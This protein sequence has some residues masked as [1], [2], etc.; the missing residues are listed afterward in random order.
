MK[1]VEPSVLIETWPQRERAWARKLGRVRLGVEPVP[2]QLRKYRA[3]TWVITIVAGGMAVFIAALFTAFKS[4]GTGLIV[5][6]VLFG[7]V[8]LSAWLGYAKL[9]S[10]ALAYL[11]EKAEVDRVTAESTPLG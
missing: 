6:G 7:P 10:R 9:E 3:V 1:P 8:I 4:P 5:A 11:R 2:D